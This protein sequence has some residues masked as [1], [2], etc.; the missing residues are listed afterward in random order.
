MPNANYRAGRRLEYLWI[1]QMKQK[2]YTCTR[3]AGSH[4][5]ID[6]LAWNEQEIIMAQIKNGNRAW[7]SADLESLRAMPRPPGVKVFLVVRDGTVKE[8]EYIPC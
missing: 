5:L 4:G 3:A 8:W 1:V 6:C 7:N 2:G